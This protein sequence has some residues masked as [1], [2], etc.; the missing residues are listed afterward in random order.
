MSETIDDLTINWEEDGL[1][2]VKEL[3]KVILSKGAW[4]TIMFRFQ[5]WDATKNE[6]RPPSYAIRRYQ[7]RN[8]AY[9]M[10]SKFNISS[11]DQAQ[12]IIDALNEWVGKSA[13]SSADSE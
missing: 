9:Q 3:D 10:K 12:K 7:K 11:D 6:Y 8:G 1:L 4:S 5:N 2:K 13:E